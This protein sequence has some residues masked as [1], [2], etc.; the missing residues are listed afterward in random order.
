MPDTSEIVRLI[1]S[2]IPLIVIESREELQVIEILSRATT[3]LRLPFYRWTITQG[4]YRL[5]GANSR[6]ETPR[7]PEEVLHHIWSMKMRGVYTLVDFHPF[8]EDPKHLRM[9]KEIGLY[10]E[11][12]NQTLIFLS[13]Q[14][15]FPD[16]LNH[17]TAYFQ[18]SL[19]SETKLMQTV[20]KVAGQWVQE[21]KH[22]KVHID[23]EALHM[24]VQNLK[25]LSLS[26]ATR[27]A[28][29]AIYDDGAISKSDLPEIAKAKHS[30]L[31]KDGIL[32]FEYDTTHLSEVGGLLHLKKW[33]QQRRSIFLSESKQNGLDAPKGIL[34]LGIQGG[35]KS[36]AAKAVAGTW[37]IPLLR[38]D[39]GA[40]FNKYFGETER[41][42]REALKMAETMAPCVLWLDEI[43]KGIATSDSDNGTSKRLLGTLLTWMA[44]RK[45]SVFIVATAND[46]QSLPPEL[47]RKGRLDEI[48]FVDLP[49]WETRQLIFS[50]HL[51]KRNL[52]PADFN[53]N[54]LADLTDK[55][56]GAEIE[57]AVVAGM[58]SAMGHSD[59]LTNDVLI[60][61][62]HST[63]PLSVV[64]KEQIDY[65]RE[66]AR[67]RTVP[68]H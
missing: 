2:R 9:I 16:E 51:K 33:L 22:Q 50:I 40:L 39:F 6:H 65:M 12:R 52:N 59:R 47:L 48:F 31:N 28:R 27:L 46:I 60:G 37:G 35:G 11:K 42:T 7:E 26:E 66:W 19:P 43:E 41:R 1:R 68:A 30:L 45:S 20:A 55:F 5:D 10:A 29:N 36:L 15:A 54:Q 63:Q 38:L 49:D 57:Q 14:C 32:S 8:I 67:E 17:L 23:K 64:M 4:L 58:Y 44:E 61:E 18:L 34:L 25:G 3:Q 56:S 62:I 13:H 21:E 53:L 24:L